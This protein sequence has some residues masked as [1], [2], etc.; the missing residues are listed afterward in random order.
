MLALAISL[1][2]DSKACS[3]FSKPALTGKVTNILY[4]TLLSCSPVAQ[5][6]SIGTHLT[7]ARMSEVNAKRN[8]R[9]HSSAL[10]IG[11]RE[12]VNFQEK[13]VPYWSFVLRWQTGKE[14]GAAWVSELREDTLPHSYFPVPTGASIRYLSGA[15]WCS[16]P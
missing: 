9:S 3:S 16:K 2:M 5:G 13:N 4:L 7:L 14:L 1:T 12:G 11:E 8:Q 15:S 10:L 6:H